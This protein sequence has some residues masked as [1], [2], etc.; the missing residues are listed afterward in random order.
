MSETKP[1]YKVI[2]MDVRAICLWKF[3]RMLAFLSGLLILVWGAAVL[4]PLERGIQAAFYGNTEWKAPALVSLQLPSIDLAS[5]ATFLPDVRKDFTAQW[6]GFLWIA[7]SGEYTFT[8]ASDDGSDVYIDGREVVDNGGFHGLQERSGSIALEKGFHRILARY[9]QGKALSVFKCYWTPPGRPRSLIPASAL[10]LTPGTPKRYLTGRLCEFLGALG[11][12][13]GCLTLAG[14]LGIRIWRWGRSLLPLKQ[15]VIVALIVLATFFGYFIWSSYA[16]SIDSIWS[17]YVAL[18]L[19][20]EGNANLDEYEQVL[21][22]YVHHVEWQHEHYYNIYPLGTPVMAVPFMWIV[23]RFMQQALS[24]DTVQFYNRYGWIPRGIEKFIASWIVAG[25]SGAI[26]LLACL[27]FSSRFAPFLL[28]FI[29]AFCSS[30][31]STASRGLWQHGPALFLLTIALY[32]LL[33]SDRRPHHRFWA[34]RLTAVCLSFSFWVRP[35]NILS[36]LLLSAYVLYR[37]RAH[38][39]GYILCGAAASLPFF[40]FNLSVYHHI[41]P[42]Y[43]RLSQVAF[44]TSAFWDGLLGNLISPSRGVFVYSPIFS[45]AFLGIGL[46][47]KDKRMSALD[48]CLTLILAGHW[49]LSSA[50]HAWW[51]GHSYGPRYFTEMTVYLCYFLIPVFSHLPQWNRVGKTI[52]V[53]LLSL[54]IG[55]SFFTHYQGAMSVAANS[56]SAYPIDVGKDP[57]RVWDWS[58]WWR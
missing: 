57:S 4:N 56:W 44:G 52:A 28:T 38:F 6:E 48:I 15:P 46:L 5:M 58:I 34:L 13:A 10:F 20:R 26:Y 50:H 54:A 39:P 32:L 3:D 30:A 27:F 31:W 51:G 11:T 33:L 7:Q 23:D 21:K 53:C 1:F 16:V 43:F 14:W 17:T 36:I 8:T 12:L 45:F 29:F 2:W 9:L 19:L 41:L 35:T 47:V 24:Q 55:W 42:T 37:H 40:L 49:M 22:K 18:S 25:A